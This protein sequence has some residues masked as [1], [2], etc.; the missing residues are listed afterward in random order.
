M[1]TDQLVNLTKEL[2]SYRTVKGRTEDIKNCTDFIKDYFTDTNVQ[3]KE[4]EHNGVLSLYLSYDGADHH[5]LLLSGHYDV[6]EADDGQFQ[7]EIDGD[8][9]I[10]RGALDM[11]TGVAIIMTLMKEFSEEKPSIAALLTSDEETGGDNGT[12]HAIERGI[13]ADLVI[14][15]EQNDAKTPEEQGIVN[16]GK[17]IFQVKITT[18]GKA[19]HGAYLWEGENAAEKLIDAYK[20]IQALFPRVTKEDHWRTSLNLGIIKAGEAANK[21]PDTAE[22]TLDFRY[23]E[24]E[25]PEDIRKKL[26]TVPDIAVE[27]LAQGPM[28]YNNEENEHIK[29]LA[30]TAEKITGKPA[31][32]IRIMGASDIR[33]TSAKNIP[34][35]LMGPWGEGMHGKDEYCLI[36]SI[37]PC[38]DT[39]AAY[40]KSLS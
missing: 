21:V 33:Y 5:Q 31:S 1:D 24:E 27:V 29:R 36:S 15:V 2:I 12:G 3:V 13:L 38:Y 8:K 9:L 39:L 35:V 40:I 32:F 7:A 30:K 17:G 18:K 26:E 37:E 20:K 16:A 23:T 6:V 11:K 4:L 14:A 19:A 34:S 25:S 10:G 22:A 28:V